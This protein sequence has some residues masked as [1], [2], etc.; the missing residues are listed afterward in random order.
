G[1]IEIEE[2]LRGIDGIEFVY[3]SETDVVRHRLVKEIIRAY[4]DQDDGDGPS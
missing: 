2:L 4:R 1:L 3:L